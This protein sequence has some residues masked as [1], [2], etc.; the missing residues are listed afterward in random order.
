MVIFPFLCVFMFLGLPQAAGAQLPVEEK[1][2]PRAIDDVNGDN[3]VEEDEQDLSAVQAR[4]ERQTAHAYAY[5]GGGGGAV[6]VQQQAQLEK[7]ANAH[8]QKI[9]FVR[10]GRPSSSSLSSLPPPSP[11]PCPCL[12]F[13]SLSLFVL[14]SSM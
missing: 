4:K 12:C 7:A 1:K 5:L 10:P 9:R 2:P 13:F 3:G 8:F 14:P 6:N 11:C